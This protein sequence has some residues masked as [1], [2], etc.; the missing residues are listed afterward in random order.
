MH[1]PAISAKLIMGHFHEHPSTLRP[2]GNTFNLSSLMAR[3]AGASLFSRLY[4]R[5]HWCKIKA[6][7]YQWLQTSYGQH[8]SQET[9]LNFLTVAEQCTGQWA[10][11]SSENKLAE[12][13]LISCMGRQWINRLCLHSL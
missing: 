9:Q 3:L 13:S 4:V 12:D 6:R 1:V 10:L 5:M 7:G 8:V 2:H 11:Q